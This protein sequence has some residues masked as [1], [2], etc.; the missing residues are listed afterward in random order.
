MRSA[1][2]TAR[3]EAPLSAPVRKTTSPFR[4]YLIPAG[5]LLR[6]ASSHG[7]FGWRGHN[8]VVNNCAPGTMVL[9]AV[10]IVYLVPIRWLIRQVM[11]NIL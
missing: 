4:I 7:R 1:E 9:L 3:G 2:R 6:I 10:G 5:R 8:P 11:I